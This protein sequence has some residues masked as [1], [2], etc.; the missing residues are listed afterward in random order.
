MSASPR[1]TKE[2]FQA[3]EAHPVTEVVRRYLTDLAAAMRH[4]WSQGENWTDEAK[5]SV[6]SLEDLATLDLESIETFYEAKDADE[7]GNP[8]IDEG[9][10]K[11]G[12]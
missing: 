9:D 8:H 4:D 10:E 11:D 5:I 6:L 7:Q 3:W 1:L 2:E 12:Y